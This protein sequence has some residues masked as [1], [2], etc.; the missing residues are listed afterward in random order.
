MTA[1]L[2]KYDLTYF[3]RREFFLLISRGGLSLTGASPVDDDGISHLT[4][5]VLFA[6]VTTKRHTVSSV[7]H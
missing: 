5:I 6:A 4:F 1:Q 3:N 7:H 2:S